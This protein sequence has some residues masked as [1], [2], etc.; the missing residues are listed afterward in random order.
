M[1]KTV[2]ELRNEIRLAVD[3]FERRGSV[4]FTK[5]SLAA[6]SEAVGGDVGPGQLPA[7]AEMRKAIAHRIDGLDDDRDHE[8]AFRKAELEIVAAV[9]DE[10]E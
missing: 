8:R 2:D 1:A 9:L 3:R 6:I 10:A 4:G 7:K 5:E